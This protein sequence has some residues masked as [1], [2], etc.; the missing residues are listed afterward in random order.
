MVGVMGWVTVDIAA[1]EPLARFSWDPRAGWM[2]VD[3]NVT[4]MPVSTS[5]Q[6]AVSCVGLVSAVSRLHGISA[7]RSRAAWTL[8]ITI[9]KHE[10]HA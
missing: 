7:F 10:F 3:E 1:P 2:A 6:F 5:K 4:D 9:Q 8:P